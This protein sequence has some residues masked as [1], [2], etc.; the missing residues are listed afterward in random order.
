MAKIVIIGAGAAGTTAGIWARKTDRKAE[1]TLVTKEKYP[2]YSRCGLPYTISKHISEFT[3]L[4]THDA[5]WYSSF[6][7]MNLLLGTEATNINVK[8]R[9]V[10]IK[11]L[12]SGEEKTLEYDALVIATGSR[13]AFPPIKGIEGKSNVYSLRTIDDAMA[14]H[15]AAKKSKRCVVVGAGL[16]GVE[17][18]E[19]LVELGVE[20]TLVEFLP[21][22]LPLM[23]DADMADM[24]EDA[25]KEHGVKVYTNT[26]VSELIG[27]TRAEKVVLKNRN[28]GE[29]ERIPTDFVVIS[30]GV[31]PNT[32][33]AVK[34][35]VAL[36]S[37]KYIKVDSRARTNIEGIYAAGD[38]TE[39]VDFV[40]GQPVAIGMGTIAVRQG[41]VAGINAAG[42]DAE[43]PKGVLLTRITKVF[44][45]EVA[46]VGPITDS[47]EKT[48]I[49]PIV[50]KMTYSSKPEYMPGGK[51]LKAKL[52][53]DE[54]GRILGAQLVGYEDIHQKINVIAA[55]MQANM[56]VEELEWL[57]TCYA[58][59]SCPTWSE[60]T[61]TAEVIARKIKKKK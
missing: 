22:V 17:T 39:Y 37:T 16:I 60:L 11:N 8:D 52:M 41:K 24:V 29:E 57:E 51:P 14:I 12:Q 26:A 32:E 20:V 35:G 53:A 2:E 54:E 34:A 59:I 36:G 28:T 10:A 46:A 21:S 45:V 30:A 42:G 19:A 25:L 7:K 49:K 58:P 47:L 50:G 55:A 38:C 9:T 61:L 56:N 1:I 27:E 4:I 44:G 18:T 40:T 6:G 15:E 31:R 33:L 13:P 23:I 5:G 48:G 43:M 3:N